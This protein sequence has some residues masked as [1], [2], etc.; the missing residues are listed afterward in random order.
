MKKT[1]NSL[2]ERI[3]NNTNVEDLEYW[4]KNAILEENKDI[5]DVRN[6]RINQLKK[7]GVLQPLHKHNIEDYGNKNKR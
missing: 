1:T 3:M 6:E 7:E 4:D 5:Q 2:L